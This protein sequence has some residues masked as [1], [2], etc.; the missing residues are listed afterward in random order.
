MTWQIL[1]TPARTQ[2]LD[3]V[4]TGGDESILFAPKSVEVKSTPLPFY[5]V[6]RLY[7]LTNFASMPILTLYYIGDGTRLFYIDGTDT[8]LMTVDS[9]RE[10]KLTPGNIIAYL[11]FYFFSVQTEDGEIFLVKDPDSYPYQDL[12]SFGIEPGVMIGPNRPKYTIEMDEQGGFIVDTPLFV[13]GTLYQ[14]RV[15]VDPH[16]RVRLSDRHMMVPGRTGNQTTSTPNGI[17]F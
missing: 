13:D 5:H 16:G 3:A 6:M 12:D 1:D 10:L 2:F 4:R 7:R 11:N 17:Y 15:L 8:P 14:A 9:L